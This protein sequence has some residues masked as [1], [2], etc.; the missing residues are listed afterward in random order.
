LTSG[1]QGADV[2]LLVRAGLVVGAAAGFLF[3]VALHASADV[4]EPSSAYQPASTKLVKHSGATP[5]DPLPAEQE[6]V[7]TETGEPSPVVVETHDVVPATPA[8]EHQV[9]P[10][11]AHI[12]R[13]EPAQH[14]SGL[15]TAVRPLTIGLERIGSFLGRVVSACSVSAGS[16]AGVPVLTLAVLSVVAAFERR[17]VLGTRFIADEDVPEL[18]YAGE[19]IA[20]G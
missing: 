9:R 5:A 14:E 3:A 20:P 2:R 11:P 12:V 16:G 17:R 8:P 6:K 10:A 7:G 19:V 1:Y 15:A 13:T 18:L 4:V